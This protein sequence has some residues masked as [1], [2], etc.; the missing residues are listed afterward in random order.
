MGPDEGVKRVLRILMGSTGTHGFAGA[1]WV[2][3][4]TYGAEARVYARDGGPPGAETVRVEADN[5]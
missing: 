5:Q 4:G 1:V 2:R 3:S